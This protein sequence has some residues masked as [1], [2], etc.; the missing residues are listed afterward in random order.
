MKI[1]K[2][3]SSAVL[4]KHLKFVFVL[5]GTNQ[6]KGSL[7]LIERYDLEFDKWFLLDLHMP[8]PLHDF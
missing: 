4:V 7:N 5:G 1:P 8:E 6:M 2:S 3:G